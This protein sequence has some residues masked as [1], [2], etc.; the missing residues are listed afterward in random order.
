[1]KQGKKNIDTSEYLALGISLGMLFGV[2]FGFCFVVNL[3]LFLLFPFGLL[4]F[5]VHFRL[6]YVNLYEE[7]VRLL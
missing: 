3:P 1:M 6:S 4:F 7:I 5:R 2:V